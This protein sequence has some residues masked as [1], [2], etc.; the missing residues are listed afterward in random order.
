[1]KA[2]CLNGYAKE[3]DHRKSA[4]FTYNDLY[5][6]RY[7]CLIITLC[8]KHIDHRIEIEINSTLR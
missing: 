8:Y 3:V 2:H 5:L 6:F 7:A 4:K 1:M